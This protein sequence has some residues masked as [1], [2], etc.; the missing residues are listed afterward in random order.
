ME[1][2]YWL[3]DALRIDKYGTV[4]EVKLTDGP[5]DEPY[6][7]KEAEQIISRIGLDKGKNR[8]YV[9]VTVEP[10]PNMEVNLNGEAIELNKS[11]L[12]AMEKRKNI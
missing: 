10:V 4:W 8:K 3:A 6:G 5:H 9:M 7:V 2:Q 12:E 1:K 11:A